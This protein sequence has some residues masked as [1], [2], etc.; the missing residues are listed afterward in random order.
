[1]VWTDARRRGFGLQDIVRWMSSAPAGLAGFAGRIGSLHAG[2]Q[3]NFV[4]FDP[5]GEF[6]VTPERLHHRH[7]ISPYMGEKLKGVI[8]ATYLRGEAVYRAGDF[9]SGK[10]GRE[11]RVC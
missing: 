1:V 3:A 5:E 7:P 10:R 2:L 8:D 6:V 11:L 9:I 4:V